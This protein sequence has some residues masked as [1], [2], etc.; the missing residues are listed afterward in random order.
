MQDETP[1][2]AAPAHGGR[3]TKPTRNDVVFGGAVAALALLGVF[4][5]WVGP[6]SASRL[7]GEVET[8][9]QNA[10]LS[11][12]QGWARATAHGQRVELSGSAPTEFALGAARAAALGSLGSGG[13]VSGG[14]T[15]V[16]AFGVDLAPAV[17]PYRLEASKTEAGVV[18][19]GVAPDRATRD[20]LVDAAR[21]LF[22]A[23]AVVDLT[24]ASGAPEGVNWGV[25]ATGAMQALARLT[26]GRAELA[27]TRLALSGQAPAEDAA[28][29]ARQLIGETAGAMQASVAI[30]GPPT[31]EAILRDGRLEFRGAV[32]SSETRA[33][34]AAAVAR[35]GGPVLVDNAAV[36]G[37]GP[38]AAPVAAALPH[39]ARF[40][41]GHIAV[42]GGEIIITG[43]ASG[44]VIG[45]LREDIEAVRKGLAVKYDVWEMTP[46]LSEVS[47]LDRT[48]LDAGGCEAAFAQ[49]MAS[50][51]ILFEPDR[52]VIDRSSGETLDKLVEI[53]RRCATFRI[54][55]QA[56][57]DA[58][59][60]RE[61]SRRLAQSRADAVRDYLIGRGV[62]A[63]HL[64]TRWLGPDG[65]P[66][67]P[68]TAASLAAN[69]DVAFKVSRMEQTP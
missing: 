19:R 13:A 44:S 36:A 45:Y 60:P 69:R 61:T 8:A 33:A 42:R 22:G 3:R 46:P 66:T 54:E 31:W 15:K 52:P 12:G 40:R 39:F 47:G 37:A 24:L 58:R 48:S 10:L 55:V 14:V 6:N 1:Q 18:I 59:G 63:T 43:Q 41:T 25:A 17:S 30:E 2:V 62:P 68:P 4:T 56:F 32:P 64:E 9:A 29:G 49:V 38:W 5:V 67:N 28:T 7:E 57:A 65:Q 34:F 26:T 51:A 20:A 21:S 53:A 50:N 11:A 27:D 23:D 16:T 35:D